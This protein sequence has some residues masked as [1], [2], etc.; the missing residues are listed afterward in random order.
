MCETLGGCG[1]IIFRGQPHSREERQMRLKVLTWL[2]VGIALIALALFALATFAP[3]TYLKLHSFNGFGPIPLRW[4]ISQ[5]HDG[6]IAQS[7]EYC[8]DPVLLSW[9]GSFG[10]GP[11]VPNSVHLPASEAFDEV[12]LIRS[13]ILYERT[14]L[15]LNAMAKFNTELLH[16]CFGH[17]RN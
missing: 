11:V 3:L 17:L 9:Y 14:K 12:T 16:Q 4:V 8:R 6:L 5:A 15:A 13:G 7:A 2:S 10:G 1:N